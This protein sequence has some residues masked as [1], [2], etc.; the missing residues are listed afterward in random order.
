MADGGS[1]QQMK[2]YFLEGKESIALTAEDVKALL[3]DG[4]LPPG[5][6][7]RRETEPAF[8]PIKD[9]SEFGGMESKTGVADE[10]PPFKGLSMEES[11]LVYPFLD[12]LKAY[13]KKCGTEYSGSFGG[14][15]DTCCS[16][17]SKDNFYLFRTRARC[18]P[19][20]DRALYGNENWFHYLGDLENWVVGVT[21]SHFKEAMAIQAEIKKMRA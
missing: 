21:L 17:I 18:E 11:R 9:Y 16:P 5:T 15:C 7:L 13:F 10:R 19:C 20:T 12:R 6:L 2:N 3:D 14:C 4:C 8:R 1:N